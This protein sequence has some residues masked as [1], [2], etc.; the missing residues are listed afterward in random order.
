MKQCEPILNAAGL[1]VKIVKTSHAG[2][3]KTLMESLEV[4]P[5]AVIV[6]GGDGTSSE[7]V[8]GLLRRKDTPCPVLLLPLGKKNESYKNIQNLTEIKLSDSCLPLV[9]ERLKHCNAFKY[10][11]MENEGEERKPIYG[12]NKICYGLFRDIEEYVGKKWTLGYLKNELATSLASFSNA[13]QWNI[14]GNITYSP[15]CPGCKKCYTNKST[16]SISK[17]FGNK[18]L[19]EEKVP[20]E[21]NPECGIK[22][23]LTFEGNQLS[24]QRAQ[25]N[26][27][28]ALETEVISDYSPGI[29]FVKNVLTSKE[30]VPSI[31]FAANNVE[32]V[33]IEKDLKYA[34][35]GNEYD[36][37]PIK[38]SL[39]P[40]A[41]KLFC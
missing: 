27:T 9:F 34:I 23:S 39:I 6:A 21:I 30:V 41:F 38:I 3:A 1:Y 4:L 15:P 32:L 10:E 14:S 7:V 13:I 37:L 36:A 16:F 40:N 33:P 24:I 5:D 26:S 12:L 18:K 28:Q 22:R 19:A 17:L 8:T 20:T 25:N 2:H 35:D 11:L 29:D 31:K